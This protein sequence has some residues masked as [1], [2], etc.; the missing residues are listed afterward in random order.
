M[1]AIKAETASLLGV[2]VLRHLFVVAVIFQHMPSHSRYSE[3][4]NGQIEHWVPL[5]DGAVAGFFL[6]SGYFFRAGINW[7]RLATRARRLLI[8]YL[9]FSFIYAVMLS[10]LGKSN[11]QTGLLGIVTGA[12]V[13]PQLYFLPYLF[14]ISVGWGLIIDRIPERYHRIATPAF[15]LVTFFVYLALP[16]SSSTGPE[17]RLVALYVLTFVWGFYRQKL[18]GPAVSYLVL[19]ISIVAVITIPWQARL[20]DLPLVLL[21]SEIAIRGSNLFRR[22]G[23]IPGSGGIYLL[24]TPILNYALATISLM[25]GIKDVANVGVTIALTYIV[26]LAATL[27]AIRAMPR[28]RAYLLE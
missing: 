16:T 17:L 25:I 20:W 14:V 21:L 23:R 1:Q 9:V 18:A 10:I 13:G 24:H 6:L 8:P 22:S 12:G 27:I 15:L 5:I 4:I 19:G 2:D 3:A 7:Q 11:F 28:I 26:A